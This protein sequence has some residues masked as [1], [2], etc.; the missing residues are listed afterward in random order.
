MGRQLFE[1]P[2]IGCAQCHAGPQ[3]TDNAIHN[4]NG[5]PVRTPNFVGYEQQPLIYTMVRHRP[6]ETL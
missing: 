3:L 2:N 5:V 4:V 1:D 6:Y